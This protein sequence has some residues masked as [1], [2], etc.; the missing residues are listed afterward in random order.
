MKCSEY[1]SGVSCNTSVRACVR[2]C[3]CA[4]VCVCVSLSLSL[5]VCACARVRVCV[6]ACVCV[7]V[8][9]C[10]CVC[11][12]VCECVRVCLCLCLCVCVCVCVF[13]PFHHKGFF[14]LNRTVNVVPEV[15][16]S[17]SML[18]KYFCY[19]YLCRHDIGNHSRN[20]QASNCAKEWQLN[21]EEPREVKDIT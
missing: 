19:K 10:V 1:A 4:C 21:R 7:C 5:C 15:Q 8:R 14:W 11:L 20:L 2:A 9:V 12:Y 6:L 16:S 17:D 18:R 13:I 3:V